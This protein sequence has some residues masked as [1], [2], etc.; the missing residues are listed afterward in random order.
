MQAIDVIGLTVRLG[1]SDIL[2][3]VTFSVASGEFVCITGPNGAGKTTLLK[4]LLGIT[5][6]V[7]GEM[8][9]FGDLAPLAA[10]RSRIGYLPQKNV[11]VN[12]LF[13]A[14]AE[15]V[16][17]TG[18]MADRSFPKRLRSDDRVM[19]REALALLDVEDLAS[20][21]FSELSGGQQQRVL[22]ARALVNRPEL[23]LLD[24]PSTALDPESREEFFA[25]LKAL[26][27]EQRIT[28]AI[29]TH[30]M[31]YVGR[32]ATKLL[33]IDRKVAYFG[34]AEAFLHEHR[35]THHHDYA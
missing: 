5:P 7:S 33:V 30:D 8:R 20:R 4:A 21:P 34:D 25:L 6:T 2:K 3:D 10:G 23:L 27:R 14:S 35:I 17:L 18:L 29:V 11:S 22:L 15:E 12:P 31:D 19:A 16:V 1:G 32:Y 28:V 13:P 24:E 9:F 26:N